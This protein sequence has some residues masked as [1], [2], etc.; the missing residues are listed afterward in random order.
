[1][2]QYRLTAT[3]FLPRRL[4]AIGALAAAACFGSTGPEFPQTKYELRAIN[5]TALKLSNGQIPGA[6]IDTSNCPPIITSGSIALTSA[7]NAVVDFWM[8]VG[9]CRLGDEY[10]YLFRIDYER[11]ASGA[12]VL[13]WHGTSIDDAP[14]DDTAL[15]MNDTMVA[16]IRAAASTPRNTWLLV[17]QP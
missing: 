2:V 15:V 6:P 8:K 7:R 14:H 12:L 5:G 13:R 10:H 16:R 9:S 3:S 11:F 1:M 17:R 4:W